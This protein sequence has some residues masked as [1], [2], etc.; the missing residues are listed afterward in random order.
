MTNPL[1]IA[2]IGGGAAGFFAAI[3]AKQTTKEAQVTIF[4]KAPK[5]LAKVEV[6]GGGRC[7]LTN[8]FAQI[9]DLRQAYPRGHQL[10]KRL[11]REFNHQD[12]MKWFRTHGVPLTI[13][14]DECVFPQAQDSHAVI[15]A[16]T[17]TA[18]KLGVKVQTRKQ[19]KELSLQ[20]EGRWQLVFADNTTRY[21][22]RVAI[23]TGGSPQRKGLGYL[24]QLGHK[25][26]APIP[27]L[28]TF[29]I[30]DKDFTSLMGTVV[31]PATV[32]IPGTKLQATGPLLITH[33]GMS[34]PATLKL[35][36]YAARVLE[37]AQYHAPIA[38][39]W[40]GERSRP[41]VEHALQQ[42][43]NANPRKQVSTLRPFEL[44]AKLWL[45]L[46]RK[47]DIQPDKPWAEVGKKGFN[48]LIETLTHDLY[49]IEG[50]GAYKEEFVTCGGVSMQSVH[51][52]TLE[53]KVCRGLFFAGEVLDVDAI[54]GGFN[55]QA[56]W[57]MGYVVGRNIVREDL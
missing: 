21:C 11:F 35:S 46:L 22:D 40:A 7:N 29:N 36:S 10:M 51:P 39:C 52:K 57:T 28:F 42:L 48:K 41:E 23:T 17:S 20:K 45:Y 50:K 15:K 43:M 34:G 6:T 5:V 37:T 49:T 54:T 8:T 47:A 9:G 27:S 53:S 4:E 12:T 3:T 18:E 14:D 38:V 56:A 25:I 32:M 2:I 16:L 24:E 30:K 19:L 31:N 26:E 13:Q 1:D 33:W 55:L 44:S